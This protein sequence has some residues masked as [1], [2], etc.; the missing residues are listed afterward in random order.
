MATKNA[1]WNNIFKSDSN[2]SSQTILALKQVP[3]FDGLSNRELNSVSK[4]V[5][6]REYDID[7][8]VFQSGTPGLGMYIILQG[9]AVIKGVKADGENIEFSQLTSGDFFG[10]ISL[11]SEDD[12]SANA[13]VVSPCKLVAF[14][15][16]DLLDII[17]RSPKLGNKI[18][19][20][21]ATVL[22]SR[23]TSTKDLL[24]KMDAV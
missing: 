5:H 17:T 23:L 14:F 15:R 24:T 6:H 8:F 13:V 19:L 22:G 7:E 4:I 12:R 20:N 21:L 3:I 11:I 10:E 9:E 16:S 2:E 18:L 1:F